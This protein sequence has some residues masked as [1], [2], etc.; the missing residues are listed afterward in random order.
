MNM[1]VSYIGP[2]PSI[3]T[4]GRGFPIDKAAQCVDSVL[5]DVGTKYKGKLDKVC[6][7]FTNKE[8]QKIYEYYYRDILI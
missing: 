1:A 8:T 2:L 6:F 3:A 7:V 5:L 4:G